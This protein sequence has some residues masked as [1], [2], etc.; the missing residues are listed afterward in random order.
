VRQSAN[1]LTKR[2]LS[3][4]K[5]RT[6]RSAEIESRIGHEAFKFLESHVDF[7]DSK[8][9]YI[10]DNVDVLAKAMLRRPFAS[11]INLKRLNELQKIDSF[12]N[13]VNQRLK[14][15]GLFIGCSETGVLRKKLIYAKYPSPIKQLIYL[16]YYIYRRISPK[17]PFTKR[18]YHFINKGRNNAM[19]K[20]E[21]F[22]RLYYGGFEIAAE[23]EI[24]L[25]NYFVA[26]KIKE[27]FVNKRPSF[28][29]LIKLN[30][31]GKNGKMIEVFKL[32][33]MHPYSE[34]LQEYIYLLNN[35][36]RGG[37]FKNDI[38]ISPLGAYLR[39]FWIDEIPMLLNLIKGDIK[40]FGVRP[41]SQ[42]YYNLYSEELKLLRL[43]HKPGLIPPYY[44]DLPKSMDEIINSEIKYLLA[45]EKSPYL[46]DCKYL[47]RALIN[48]LIKGNLSK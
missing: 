17:L 29:P 13:L 43:K 22:G 3:V 2:N 8:S 47:F 32:R 40:L 36:D 5:S 30:R 26:R 45:Y 41:I 44:V 7:L 27:P 25:L 24:G 31:V 28:Y 16:S 11:I 15:G 9:F 34:Y 38:R 39:K 46:T 20:V 33:T 18:I 42:Q 37:K 23:E 35:L 12:I 48:I 4:I 1:T 10:S 14:T 19:S 6:D 21:L